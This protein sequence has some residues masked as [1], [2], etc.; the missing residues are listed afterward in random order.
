VTEPHG[1]GTPYKRFHWDGWRLI[2]EE[3]NTGTLQRSY[4]QQP[5]VPYG[6]TLA[7]APG[8]NPGA[9]DYRYFGRD[10]HGSTRAIFAQD[11]ARI[12]TADWHPYGIQRQGFGLSSAQAFT[13]QWKSSY[14]GDYQFGLRTYSPGLARWLSRDSLGYV[15]GPNMHGYAKGNP[16][17]F[18]D[19]QGGWVIPVAIGIGIG[20]L[21]GGVAAYACGKS[22]GWGIARGA[23]FGGLL[24]GVAMVTAIPLGTALGATIGGAAA[25]V[26][27]GGGLMGAAS[28]ITP[29]TGLSIA[30]NITGGSMGLAGDHLWQ[31]FIDKDPCGWIADNL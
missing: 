15:D 24:T 14:S 18:V 10:S 5:G 9:A 21:L 1:F 28:A 8:S 3:D 23:A 7:E 6:A 2:G 19:A 20:G 30:I 16:I 31:T 29:S 17:A 25:E 26:A 4:V 13:G 22:V 12:G 27:V 11:K